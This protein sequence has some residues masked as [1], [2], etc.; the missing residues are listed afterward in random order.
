MPLACAAFLM[1]H[2]GHDEDVELAKLADT[3]VCYCDLCNDLRT[4][5]VTA[6]R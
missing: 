1:V 4:F 3:L 6:R 2:E 5:V